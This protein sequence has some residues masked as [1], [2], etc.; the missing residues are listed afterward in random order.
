KKQ[1]AAELMQKIHEGAFPMGFVESFRNYVK[2]QESLVAEFRQSVVRKRQN[3]EEAAQAI[4]SHVEHHQ[5]QVFICFFF[6]LAN[7][8]KYMYMYTLLCIYTHD[9]IALQKY[10]KF[11]EDRQILQLNDRRLRLRQHK[12]CS[13]LIHIFPIGMK[14]EENNGTFRVHSYTIRSRELPGSVDKVMELIGTNKEEEM[15]IG[16]GHIAHLCMLL[17]RY[18]YIPLRHPIEYRGSRSYIIDCFIEA[19]T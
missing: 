8:C 11:N 14:H 16:L 19:E 6:F 12:M 18:L 9:M 13:Q 3:L 2:K 15:N 5:K 7:I 1:T 17:C 4:Q 10:E